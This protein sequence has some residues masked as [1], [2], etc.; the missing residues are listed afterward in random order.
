MLQEGLSIT[1]KDKTMST[2]EVVHRGNFDHIE[3]F[4][5][6][7]TRGSYLDYVLNKYGQAGV[8]ALSEA[9]PKRTGKTAASWRCDI[10]KENDMLKIVWSNTNLAKGYANVAILIQ[11]GHGTGTGGYVQGR[12][13]INP[14]LRPIFDRLAEEAWQEVIKL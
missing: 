11:K 6:A 8:D 13:Y 4:L 5:G 12:D 1:V 14:A 2:I 9:T 10:V 7:I 3:K